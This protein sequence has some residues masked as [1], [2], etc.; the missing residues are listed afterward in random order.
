MTWELTSD[1]NVI[2]LRVCLFL[3]RLQG[4]Q[5]ICG[6]DVKVC[7]VTVNSVCYVRSYAVYVFARDTS[8]FA[9]LMHTSIKL[10]TMTHFDVPT[11]HTDHF[12]TA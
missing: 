3:S 9:S 12:I 7:E 2:I 4:N 5:Q 6:T 1:S 11:R 8:R 10:T